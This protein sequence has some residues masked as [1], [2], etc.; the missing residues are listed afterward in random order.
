M[1]RLREFSHL[2]PSTCAYLREARRKGRIGHAYL[3]VGD[4]P[5][6]MLDF[7]DA[8]VQVCA[9]QNPSAA[10]EACGDCPVCRS[11]TA[12]NYATRFILKPQSKSRQILIDEV[13]QFEHQL[14]LATARGRLKI[15]IIA[16]ADCM[17]E[18]AQNAF[19][20]TLEEPGPDTLLVLITSRPRRLL[21]T[22]RSRCQAVSLLRNRKEYGAQMAHGLFDVLS[23]LRR[24]SGAAV[25]LR[26]AARL[27]GMFSELHAEAEQTISEHRD[28]KWDDLA[29]EDP[30]LRKR[31]KDEEDAR[32]EAEYV[33]LRQEFCDAVHAWFLQLTLVAAGLHFEKLPHPEF[34]HEE[35]PVETLVASSW[36]AI[37]NVRHAEELA[38]CLAGNVPEDLAIDAFCLAVTARN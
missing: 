19:L 36:E 17:G 23:T 33:R 3:F 26:A 4:D 7:V 35:T 30:V 5:A 38:A 32:I 24:G 20:K 13:R 11:L 16:D 29:G 8:W 31:L 15:G 18:E 28:R 25:G 22:I 14:S 34:L 6:L 37:E 2:F 9:C 21:P 1:A 12:G 10:G 27:R